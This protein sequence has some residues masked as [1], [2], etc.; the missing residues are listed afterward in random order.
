[1]VPISLRIS[2]L[3][4]VSYLVP[5]RRLTSFVPNNIPLAFLG[6]DVFVSVAVFHASHFGATDHTVIH[7]GFD[8]LS[9]R[10]YVKDPTSEEV[11][12][13]FL[14]C[15]V[16]SETVLRLAHLLGY[17]WDPLS[18]RYTD[19]G[20]MGQFNDFHSPK[21]GFVFDINTDLNDTRPAT[22]LERSIF[23]LSNGY[24]PT[25]RGTIVVTV[26]N[27]YE[28][29]H[30]AHA[31]F[32]RCSILSSLGLVQQDEIERPHSILLFDK[33]VFTVRIPGSKFTLRQPYRQQIKPYVFC[34]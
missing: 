34:H 7:F 12:P 19:S 5:A 8:H 4:Y 29:M 24:F 1:M 3:M 31:R 25:N 20:L 21:N 9:I 17:Q 32:V 11:G 14:K 26:K 23:D 18:V 28:G 6:S 22:P 15:S 30:R 10:T 16:S 33:A 27:R 13:Y 2:R